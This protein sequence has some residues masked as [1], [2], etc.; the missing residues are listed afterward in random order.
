MAA[1]LEYESEERNWHRAAP[2]I[3]SRRY[4]PPEI[5]NGALQ[6]RKKISSV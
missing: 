1:T 4:R 3:E 5:R 6:E 2:G